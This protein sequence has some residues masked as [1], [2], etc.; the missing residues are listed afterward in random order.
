MSE[1]FK[2]IGKA[3]SVAEIYENSASITFEAK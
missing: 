1:D 3:G 2:I